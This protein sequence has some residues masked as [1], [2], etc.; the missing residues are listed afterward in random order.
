MELTTP[1]RGIYWG[2]DKQKDLNPANYLNAYINTYLKEEIYFE[3][4]TRNLGS[5]TRFLESASFS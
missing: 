1:K 2:Y 4:I 5:F 3:G